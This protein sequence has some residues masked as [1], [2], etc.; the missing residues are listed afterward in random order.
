[1]I[2]LK[3]GCYCIVPKVSPSNWDKPGASTKEP[4]Y[5]PYK[6]HDP[7]FQNDPRYLQGLTPGK[8]H[9]RISSTERRIAT[10]EL[11]A[12]ELDSL[13]RLNFN[14][15]KLLMISWILHQLSMLHPIPQDQC[16]I[17]KIHKQ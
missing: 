15:D 2:K 12:I 13:Q 5:I 7:E 3:H 17:L 6:F 11:L 16:M 14:P 8:G 9:E 4:W 10:K 1:M